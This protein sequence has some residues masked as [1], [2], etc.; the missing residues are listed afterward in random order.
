MIAHLRQLLASRELL[1]VWASRE[2]K[3][4][5]KQSLLGVLW[6]VLQPVALTIMFTVVF[7]Y[8]V[9][10]P[11]DGV[12]YPVFSYAALVPWT[13][14]ST[15]INFGVPSLVNNMNLITK[16]YFPREILPLA[17]IVA[18]GIDFLISAALFIGLMV[19]YR[20]PMH[21][22]MA[23]LPVL[24]L[25]QVALAFGVT[26]LGAA[27]LVFFRDVRFIVP[28]FLQMWLYASPVIYPV[29]MIPPSWQA[30]YRLNPMVGILEA[31]RDILLYQR[32]PGATALLAAASI[33][34]VVLALSYALFKR[35]EPRFADMI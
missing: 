15:A 27:T 13:F 20:L 31:Y 28:L 19:F 17:A 12:P 21:P 3:V 14:L 1:F 11:T 16:I 2:V 10:V 22:A 34:L 35:L 26:L 25:I 33:A 5:Y 29:S 7:S 18:A 23:L 9:R 4:R 24:I 32:W 6:A 30:I 8:V